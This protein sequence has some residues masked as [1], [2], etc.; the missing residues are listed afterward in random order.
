M[1]K[2]V[3]V[4]CE[5][6]VR[7]DNGSPPERMVASSISSLL[8]LI[9]ILMAF[10]FSPVPA[11]AAPAA[12]KKASLIP[13]WSPQA[14]FA[15]YYVALNKGIYRKHGIDLTIIPG[16]P[17]QSPSR[18]L[19]SGKADFAVLWLGTAIQ[20]YSAGVRLTNL[21]QIVQKS[22]LM[23][24]ARKSSGI[25]SPADL[26]GRKVGLWGGDFAVPLQAFLKKYRLQVRE[27]PQSYTVNLFLRG[28]I[29]ATSAMW[30]NEY[31]TIINS[32]INHEELNLFFLHEHGINFPE[33]GLYAL[34]ETCRK[35]PA[36]ADAFVKASL[37]GWRYAFD[38]TD[39][40]LEIVLRYMKE[41]GIPANRAHQKWMLEKM[42]ELIL[43]RN[44]AE[45]MGQ[46]KPSDYQSVSA[47]LL[48]SGV[49]RSVPMYDDFIR[50]SNVRQ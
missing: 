32:G 14:Q 28:G 49:V 31:H 33:D 20:Q 15:G 12:L 22:S 7:S 40:A 16:G 36:L 5:T 44:A 24:V 1:L 13:L 21:A 6:P 23:L 46:L 3:P 27:I 25:A 9:L 4:Y 8:L 29:D 17:E 10:T 30:Y 38:H 2:N 50:R 47:E 26:R 39:E 11:D 34:E 41:A 42:R 35:D 43:P 48:G 45:V 37:E 18:F 19:K